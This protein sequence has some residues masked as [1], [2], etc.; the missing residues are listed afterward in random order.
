MSFQDSL[1]A[2]LLLLL[3]FLIL[4]TALCLPYQS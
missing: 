4:R 1:E 3:S 2:F